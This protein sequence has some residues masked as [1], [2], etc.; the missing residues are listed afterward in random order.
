MS[1]LSWKSSVGQRLTA[2]VSAPSSPQPLAVFRIG[3]ATLLLIQAWSLAES[4]PELLGNRGWVPW[5]VSEVLASPAVPRVDTVVGA[6]APL[7]ISQAAGIQGLAFLYVVALLGLLV[8]LHTRLSAVA[9]WVIH[10]VLLNSI[11][12]F[13]YGVET[14]AHISL[15]YC[16]VMPVGAAFSLDVQSGRLSGAHSAL[17]TLSLRMLQLHL[18]LIYLSTGLEKLLGAVWWNGTALWEVLMQPQY[19]QFDFAWLA[20]VP[21]LVK[22]ST[23]G[24]LAVEVGY[25]FCVWPRRTR[26]LWVAL[27]LAMHL[28][29]A[30]MMGLWLFSGMMAVLTFAAFGWPLV[31]EAMVTRV[32]AA[33]LLPFH[34][35]STR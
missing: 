1:A 26:G 9:A 5:S 7:G 11:S 21:W 4:L 3:V 24:T 22:L 16:A 12:F 33:V 13:S 19:G 32:R 6:L 34:S 28:G 27:T 20:V 8:G 18:C 2:F 25:A 29:I 10:T 17:A 31:A 15:F 23:W 35:S 14:F 30:V